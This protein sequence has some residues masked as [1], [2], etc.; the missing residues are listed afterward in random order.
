MKA[1]FEPVSEEVEFGDA[2]TYAVFQYRPANYNQM[3]LS[4]NSQT[5]DSTGLLVCAGAHVLTRFLASADG[6]ALLDGKRV[7]ELGCG[8]GAVGCV[9]AVRANLSH[10]TLTD[11]DSRACALAK[12]NLDHM[13]RPTK[14]SLE[15]ECHQLLWGATT[16]PTTTP[17]VPCDVVIGCELMYY[18]TNVAD[19]I[20]TVQ[21]L[22]P[23]G[24]F[25][26]AHLFRHEAHG[27]TMRAVLAATGWNSLVVP[28]PSFA[29]SYWPTWLN[30]CCLVSGPN[31]QIDALRRVHPTWSTFVDV[32]TTLDENVRVA[33]DMDL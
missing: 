32:E 15:T 31:T 20:W 6:V 5:H 13:V 33:E 12:R 21:S 29:T 10:L 19:L 9:A 4:T 23:A 14:P 25:L 27:D 16:F 18:Q 30:V 17:L 11:G 7:V 26:H 22:A 24:L 2:G 1:E 3:C 8:T 28:V